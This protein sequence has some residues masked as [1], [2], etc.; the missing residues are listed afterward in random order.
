MLLLRSIIFWDMQRGHDPT[1]PEVNIRR[2]PPVV[3]QDREISILQ[4]DGV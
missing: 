2:L 3:R 1:F 4:Q